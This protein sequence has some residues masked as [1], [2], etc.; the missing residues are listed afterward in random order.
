MADKGLAQLVMCV[1]KRSFEERGEAKRVAEEICLDGGPL[2]SVYRCPQCERYHL[3][4]KPR[5]WMK[6]S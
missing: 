3:T 5:P 2:L 1:A 4:S 6:A